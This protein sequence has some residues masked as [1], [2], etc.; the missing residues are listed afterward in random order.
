MKKVVLAGRNGFEKN[1]HQLLVGILLFD[2]LSRVKQKRIYHISLIFEMIFEDFCTNFNNSHE[3]LGISAD[4]PF[5]L[6]LCF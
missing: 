2:Y 1:P 5:N 6:W 3:A 4:K